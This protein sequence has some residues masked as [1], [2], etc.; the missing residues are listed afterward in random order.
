M[1]TERFL[2]STVWSRMTSSPSA[3]KASTSRAPSTQCRPT[4]R[5]LKRPP[6]RPTGHS[7]RSR[8][9]RSPLRRLRWI[10]S[11]IPRLPRARR[12]PLST[13]RKSRWEAAESS[14][15]PSLLPI[16]RWRTSKARSRNSRE[17]RKGS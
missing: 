14:K 4:Q 15:K 12:R 11:R 2:A 13:V 9:T 16:T 7:T 1:N 17:I 10:R 5:S 8:A 3:T 6:P